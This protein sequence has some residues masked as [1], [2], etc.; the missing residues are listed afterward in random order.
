MKSF[1]L[2]GVSGYIAP[3]HLRA[4]RDTENRLV[5]AVAPHDSA[6]LLDQY[7]FDSRFFTEIERFNRHLEKLHRSVCPGS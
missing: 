5:A 1:A 7:S 2:I 3:R 6:G 4:S